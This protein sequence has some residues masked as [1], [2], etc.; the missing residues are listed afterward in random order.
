MMGVALDVT[1]RK[2]A[3]EALM[4]REA[5]LAEA[6]QIAHV[7][8]YEWT[9]ADNRVDRSVELCRIFGLS[10]E[11]FPATI[12]GYLARVYP[13]DRSATRTIIEQA[14]RG[15]QIDAPSLHNDRSLQAPPCVAQQVLSLLARQAWT[16]EGKE[17]QCAI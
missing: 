4:R 3:E 6:Q 1:D 14:F 8:S 12:E 11:D 7:G 13:D 16:N 5:Q 17:S 2:H 15:I 9:V 10:S